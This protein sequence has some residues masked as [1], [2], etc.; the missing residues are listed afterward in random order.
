MH[1]PQALAFLKKGLACSLLSDLQQK[2]EASVAS[3]AIQSPCCGPDTEALSTLDAVDKMLTAIQQGSSSS[4]NIDEWLRNIDIPMQLR[5]LY[6]PTAMYALRA[7]SNNTPGK[8]RQRARADGKKRRSLIVETVRDMF[9][10]SIGVVTVTLDLDDGSIK[11]P[12]GGSDDENDFP[13]VSA[14]L[15]SSAFSPFAQHHHLLILFYCRMEKR[16]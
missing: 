16:H 14:V 15:E 8:Q 7:D 1:N 2:V 4:T 10:E 13:K 9:P 5:V 3:S 11:Q 12:D 6:I